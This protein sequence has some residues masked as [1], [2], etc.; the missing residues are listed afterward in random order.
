M[1][2]YEYACLECDERYEELRPA[3]RADM[4]IPCTRCGSTRVK[5]LLSVFAAPRGHSERSEPGNNGCACGGQC[6]CHN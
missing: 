1:P 5:R 4:M 3:S 6:S 2:L